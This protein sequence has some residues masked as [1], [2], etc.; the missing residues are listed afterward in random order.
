MQNSDLTN[1]SFHMK[2]VG[3]NFLGILNDLK[4]RPED[5]SKELGVSLEKL[6]DIIQ[7]KELL[8]TEIITKAIKIWPVNVSDFHII[9]DDTINGIKIMSTEE[10][11][12]NPSIHFA[13]RFA[14][15]EAI[16]K[17]VLSSGLLKQISMKDI[18]II[19][20]KNIPRV[21]IEL[22]NNHIELSISL[23]AAS[24]KIS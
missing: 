11:K 13:G 7:G 16:K 19:S 15:K 9:F 8:S 12:L 17:A 4:R 3:Q 6:I 1:E 2:K 14:G 5:A 22:L 20:T 21:S 23:Q 10:S 18:E 24:V